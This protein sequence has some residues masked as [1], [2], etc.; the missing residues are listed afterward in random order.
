MAE[1]DVQYRGMNFLG[2]TVWLSGEVTD[3][4]VGDSGTGYAECRIE[5]VN[6]RG[7]NIMPGSAVV[8]LPTAQRPRPEFPLDWERDRGNPA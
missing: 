8:A 3:T 7:Q 1:V 2:D 6:Q 4:W 5:G